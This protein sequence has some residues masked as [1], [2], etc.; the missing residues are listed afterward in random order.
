MKYPVRLTKDDNGT[1]LVR[2][3]DFPEAHT[4]GATKAEA[5][6]RAEDALATVIDAGPPTHSTGVDTVPRNRGARADR[7]QGRAL[8]RHAHPESRKG[9]A[10]P[11]AEVARASS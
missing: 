10:R 3:L 8:R 2:F 4:F 7:P 1:V 5:L 6:A 9:R 11:T